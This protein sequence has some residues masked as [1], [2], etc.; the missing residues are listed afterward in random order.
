[1]A[2]HRLGQRSEG[3]LHAVAGGGEDAARFAC[4]EAGLDRSDAMIFQR[5]TTYKNA[6]D[7]RDPVTFGKLE[8]LMTKEGYPSFTKNIVES[9]EYFDSQPLASA[10]RNLGFDGVIVDK[11]TYPVSGRFLK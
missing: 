5:T 1:M 6:L 3:T 10:L 8:K 9:P 4:Q 11:G 7:L 2:D